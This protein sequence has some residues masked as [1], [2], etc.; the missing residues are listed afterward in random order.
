MSVRKYGLP[1]RQHQREAAFQ[2]MSRRKH[3]EWHNQ[4][5]PM[6]SK[7]DQQYKAGEQKHSQLFI[8]KPQR[9]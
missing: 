6:F 8:A 4:Q 1:D 5:Q 2:S 7:I 9:N 3:S